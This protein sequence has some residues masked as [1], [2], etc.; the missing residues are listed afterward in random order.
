MTSVTRDSITD[1]YAYDQNGN[2][3]TGSGRRMTCRVE[4]GEIFNQV[5]NAENRLWVVQKLSQGPCPAA[6]TLAT[7]YESARWTFMGACPERWVG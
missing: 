6:N 7:E 5:Y 3:S 1:T 4:D 2:P